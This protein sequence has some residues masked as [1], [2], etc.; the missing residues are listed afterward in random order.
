MKQIGNME[1]HTDGDK[2]WNRWANGRC[3]LEITF[4]LLPLSTPDKVGTMHKNY[5]RLECLGG[6]GG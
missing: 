1:K 4:L 2:N 5:R 3:L 6:S